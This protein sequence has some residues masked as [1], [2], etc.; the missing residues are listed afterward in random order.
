[1]KSFLIGLCLFLVF[2]T[3]CSDSTA[4]EKLNGNGTIAST[5]TE[6]KNEDIAVDEETQNEQVTGQEK[7]VEGQVDEKTHSNEEQDKELIKLFLG[8]WTNKEEQDIV[9]ILEEGTEKVGVRDGQL[10]T[11]AEFS[12]TEVNKEEQYIII[13]GYREEIVYDEENTAKEEF[14]SKLYLKNEGKELVYVA[15]YLNENYESQWFK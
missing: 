13:Q 12:I 6:L 14:T 4:T 2:L 7:Q 9:L 1:M 8:E 11:G 15:D 5:N 10:L 3:G